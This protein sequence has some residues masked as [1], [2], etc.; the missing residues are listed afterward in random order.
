MIAITK[1][2]SLKR[3]I[4][5]RGFGEEIKKTALFNYHVNKLQASSMVPFAGY[6]MPIFYKNYGVKSEHEGCRAGAAVFDVSHM[7]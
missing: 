2:G 5:S 1:L 7:G 4:F 6:S 3:N